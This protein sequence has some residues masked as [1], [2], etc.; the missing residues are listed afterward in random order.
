MIMDLF[1]QEVKRVL[2]PQGCLIMSTP[3]RDIYSAIGVPP[4]PYHES[5]NLTQTDFINLVNK[6][7]KHRSLFYQRTL[8]GSAL[9][10]QNKVNTLPLTF[11]SRGEQYIECSAGLSPGALFSMRCC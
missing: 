1:M 7:F 4:N 6:Y 11:E 5:M 2:R 10:A 9:I 3:D 8:I